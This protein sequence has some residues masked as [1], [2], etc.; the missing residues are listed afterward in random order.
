MNVGSFDEYLRVAADASCI[1]ICCRFRV[2]ESATI[3]TMQE[4]IAIHGNLGSI[5]YGTSIAST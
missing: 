4:G 2:A 3:H 1:V 5:L